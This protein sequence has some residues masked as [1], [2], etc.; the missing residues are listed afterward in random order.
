MASGDESWEAF[1]T[2]TLV[3]R[4]ERLVYTGA[5]PQRRQLIVSP[6][7]IE[8]ST[9]P[10]V[11]VREPRSTANRPLGCLEDKRTE[12]SCREMT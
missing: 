10:A 9:R 7:V 5:V 12:S 6:T 1:R 3:L 2:E 4:M 8:R 11:A